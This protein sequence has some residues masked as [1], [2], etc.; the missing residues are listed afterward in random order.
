MR[1]IT[2]LCEV[3]LAFSLQLRKYT[4][5]PLCSP[6]MEPNFN[7]YPANYVTSF[8]VPYDYDSVLHYG[9]FAFSQNGLPTIVPRVSQISVYSNQLAGLQ[10]GFVVRRYS[11]EFNQNK[12][13]AKKKK[14]HATASQCNGMGSFSCQLFGR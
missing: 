6:G 14:R 5:K 1:T 2:S 10:A 7:A 12:K 9:R 11:Q 4:K 13:M 8:G 3:Y